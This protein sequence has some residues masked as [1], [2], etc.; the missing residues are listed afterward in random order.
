MPFR[1]ADSEKP[2]TIFPVAGQIQPR[3]SSSISGTRPD[4]LLGG[5][6]GI[7]AGAALAVVRAS[8]ASATDGAGAGDCCCN[9]PG[10][11]SEYRSLIALGSGLKGGGV[12][13]PLAG[14]GN[15][16]RGT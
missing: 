10:A 11:C 13:R 9:C 15:K 16:G 2:A 4:S 6:A 14:G 12:G 8:G 5:E 3:L 1:F 7:V